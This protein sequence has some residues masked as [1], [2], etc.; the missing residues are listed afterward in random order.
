MAEK[1]KGGSPEITLTAKQIKEV[2]KLS[3]YLTTDQVADYF[4]I[5]RSTFYEIRKRQPEVFEQYKKGK[6]LK[7]LKYAKLLEDKAEG[8]N[9]KADSAS[10]MFFLK[11]QAGWSSKVQFNIADDATPSDIIK[12][13][14]DAITEGNASIPEVKQ[15]IELAQAKQQLINSES[16]LVNGGQL[17]P[18]E[19]ITD[20]LELFNRTLENIRLKNLEVQK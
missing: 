9:E 8:G 4:C 7:I 14:T 19:Y 5:A 12:T 10:I 20:N 1:N 16:I 15:L 17:V 6:S 13:A 2:A 18:N 3:A 11:T